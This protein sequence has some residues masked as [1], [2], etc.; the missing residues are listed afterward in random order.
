MAIHS[1]DIMD[2][3]VVSTVKN[4]EQI[5]EEQCKTFIKDRLIDKSKLI[6]DTLKKNNLPTFG[7]HVKKTTKDK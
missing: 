1:K 3:S 7:K 5:G 6:S 2:A 4:A